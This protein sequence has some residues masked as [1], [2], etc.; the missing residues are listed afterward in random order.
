LLVDG[1]LS[2]ALIQKKNPTEK[3]FSTVFWFNLG[4]GL[5]LYALLFY[6]A[7]LIARFY[8]EPQLITIVKISGLSIVIRALGIVHGT[9]LV[10][11]LNFKKQAF[12][13]IFAMI[14]SGIIGVILAFYGYGVWALVVQFLM[15]NTLRT[16]LFWLSKSYWYPKILFCVNSFKSLFK[17]GSRYMLTSFIDTAYK[18][19]FAVFIG[20]NYTAQNLGF[21]HKASSLT[22]LLTTNV[23]YTVS[24]SFIPLQ[25]S[26]AGDPTEQRKLFDRFLSLGCFIV[27]PIAI[28]LAVLAEPFVATILTER[29]LPAVPFIQVLSLSYIW[30]PILVVNRQMLLSKG[31]SKQNLM[32]DILAKTL[33]IAAFLIALPHGIIWICIS[34]GFY[35]IVD[36]TISLFFA[37]KYV[38]I[39]IIEQLKTVAPM[40]G[41][42]VFSGAIAYFVMVGIARNAPTNEFMR[43]LFGGLSGLG[44]YALGAHL[45]K[46]DE[47]KFML[48]YLKITKTQD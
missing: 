28:L 15:N 27:F 46:L 17:F 38:S 37:K 19:M 1:G 45:L 5:I 44:I 32:I 43:L 31:F 13:S 26:L 3:D 2:L 9:R 25:T 42:A 11:A 16:L 29:W 22:N 48:N 35:A 30:Y 7:P 21:F 39:R 34:I 8:Q 10:I 41:L 33:G 23:A 12:I 4:F 14:S 18:N 24:S 47:W 40:F 6:G 36:M 20:K